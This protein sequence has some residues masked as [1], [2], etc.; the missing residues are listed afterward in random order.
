MSTTHSSFEINIQPTPWDSNVFGLNTFEVSMSDIGV[1]DTEVAV[2]KLKDITTADEASLFYC[3]TNANS[4][5]NKAILYKSGFFNCETQ[6]LVVNSINK[7]TI[8]LALG[9]RRLQIAAGTDQDYID[10]VEKSSSVFEYSRF[11][12]DPFVSKR[13]S[14]LRMKY[15]CR[16]MHRQKV[17]LLV[18]RNKVNELD[19][20]IFYRRTD[21]KRVELILGGSMPSKGVM[22]TL[23]WASFIDYFNDLGIKY[24]ETKISAS[25]IV[26]VNIYMFFNFKIKSTYFDCHKHVHCSLL[27]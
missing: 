8:P 18:F 16:D 27:E 25:N 11:H 7:N 14:N 20:F 21:D 15:W 13:L 12:E 23:F 24:I 22:T 19:S 4:R 17:P 5:I 1:S 9:K 2:E 10:V 6:L 26:V 3:R